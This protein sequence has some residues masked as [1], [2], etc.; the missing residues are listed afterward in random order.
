[1]KGMIGGGSEGDR[2]VEDGGGARL[3]PLTDTKMTWG[4]SL[5]AQS[6][7]LQLPMQVV[8]IRSPVGKLRSHMGQGS[9]QGSLLRQ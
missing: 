5:V 1:M 6:L 8:Q 2:A 3:E 9:G 4:A 7:R